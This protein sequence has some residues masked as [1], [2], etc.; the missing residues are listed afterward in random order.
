MDANA[1]AQSP[2][3][4]SAAP[5]P[6]AGAPAA[7]E[8]SGASAPAPA[9]PANGW[10]ARSVFTTDIQEREPLDAVN[11]LSNDYQLVFFFTDLR[12]LTGATIVHRWTWNGTLM[13]EVPIE[14]GGPRWRAYSSK[15]LHS[16][17]L[18]SWTAQVVDASGKVLSEQSFAYTEAVEPPSAAPEPAQLPANAATY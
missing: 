13:A 10:V 11:E 1:A 8:E 2:A 5:M 15:N 7:Q 4:E 14:V 12:D 3:A 17:W 9:A 18:G 16:S 6:T